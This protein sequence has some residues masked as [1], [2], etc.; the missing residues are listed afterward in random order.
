MKVRINSVH[1]D[2]SEKLEKFVENKVGKLKHFYDDIISAEVFL[3]IEKPQNFDNKI[4]EIKIEIPGSELFAKKQAATFEEATDLSIEAL[5][6][7]II[8]YK[9]KQ[10]G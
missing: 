4:A 8:K 7:Q 10:R 3:R 5:R 1:F 9:D 2:A 6:N